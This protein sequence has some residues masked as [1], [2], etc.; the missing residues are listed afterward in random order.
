MPIG[1]PVACSLL[2]LWC[3]A[4]DHRKRPHLNAVQN[5]EPFGDV[6]YAHAGRFGA[7]GSPPRA[8]GRRQRDARDCSASR[9]TPTCVGTATGRCSLTAH[10]AVHP[11]VRGD[12]HTHPRQPRRGTGSPPRAW[13]RR[14]TSRRNLA[15][16]GSPPRA[17][18]RHPGSVRA[19]RRQRFTPTCVG[20]A[21]HDL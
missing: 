3:P 1:V 2:R 13:G 17:W 12:G 4:V 7:V 16:H 9:F 14:K 19:D 11:H 5:I 20:T 10:R 8:W 18:K 15:G 6:G 21:V